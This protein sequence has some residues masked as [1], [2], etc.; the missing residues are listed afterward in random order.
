[1]EI[2]YGFVGERKL[3]R[4]RLLRRPDREPAQSKE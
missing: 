1:V 4:H 3:R 2:M